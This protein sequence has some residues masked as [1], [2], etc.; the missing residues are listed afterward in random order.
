MAFSGDNFT[1]LGGNARTGHAPVAWSY[2]TA[3]DTLADVEGANY[4]G[5]INKW[6]KQDEF[7][8]VV[9]SD[10]KRIYTILS[11]DKLLKIVVLDADAFETG[12]GISDHL[13]LTN[14]GVNS[15]AVIDVALGDLA[16]HLADSS[17]HFTVGSIDHGLLAGLGDDDHSQ[18]A[19][20]AGRPASQTLNGGTG[21]GDTLTLRGSSDATLGR[22]NVESP[23]ELFQVEDGGQTNAYNLQ[24]LDTHTTATGVVLQGTVNSNRELNINTGIWFVSQIIDQGVYN[25]LVT[26]GF[27]A[28]TL[29][30]AFPVISTGGPTAATAL[31]GSVGVQVAIIHEN[32]GDGAGI[33]SFRD[34]GLAYRPGVRTT[35]VGDTIF[36]TDSSAVRVFPQLIAEAVGSTVTL[37]TVRGV[38]IVEPSTIGHVGTGIIGAYIGLDMDNIAFGTGIKVAVRCALAAAANSFCIQHTGTAQSLFGGDVEID[39][40]LNH[41]GNN[42][43]FYGTAPAAQSAAYTRNATIVEDRTLL[44]SASATVINNNNVLAALISDLQAIGILA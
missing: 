41:D 7:I 10:G 29:F 13:L 30:N 19:L 22:I 24:I 42:I 27:S 44:A 6:V 1:P 9:A 17:I 35:T 43:G 23:I 8:Y 38:H 14:I 28:F 5:A 12:A 34:D 16:T 40:D 39:G 18:Y 31:I 15:H 20:L 21:L 33:G 32:D 2:Q 4:F 37:T 3:V 11:V 26:P 36:K 25:Q